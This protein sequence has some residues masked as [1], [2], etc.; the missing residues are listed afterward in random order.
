LTFDDELSVLHVLL[1]IKIKTMKKIATTLFLALCLSIVSTAQTVNPIGGSAIT[2]SVAGDGT[3]VGV[4]ISEDG[5]TLAVGDRFFA[6]PN[7]GNDAGRVRVFK[8]ENGVWVPKGQNLQDAQNFVDYWAGSW[9]D[10]SPDG[11]TMIVGVP[12]LPTSTGTSNSGGAT[13][14]EYD[15]LN[16]SWNYKGN[17]VLANSS[18]SYYGR[19]VA[20]SNSGDVIHV[21]SYTASSNQGRVLSYYYNNGTWNPMGWSSAGNVSLKGTTSGEWYGYA[22]EARTNVAIVGAP[23]GG[24]S[25]NAGY[26]EVREFASSAWGTKGSRINGPSP[27]CRFGSSVEISKDGNRFIAGGYLYNG[28]GTERGYAACYEWDG[29]AWQ[30]LGAPFIGEN[31]GDKLGFGTCINNDGDLVAVAS[32]TSDS[33][34][35]EAGLVRVYHWDGTSW[36]QVGNTL[37]GDNAGDK[38]GYTTVMDGNILAVGAQGGEY[39]KTYEVVLNV[40]GNYEIK[41]MEFKA[42]SVYPNPATNGVN[43]SSYENVEEVIISNIAGQMVYQK[44]LGNTA[45]TYLDLSDLENGVYLLSLKFE[46]GTTQVEKVILR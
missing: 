31:D 45:N 12:R 9:I 35:V 33:A 32:H 6:V 16:N 26:V 14:Y 41:E 37:F 8:M 38:F 44:N 23:E 39:V 46:N 19:K 27:D 1:N 34:G 25:G 22:L 4:S 42:A 11:N 7:G 13:I 40:L 3:G 30:M 15:S 17:V 43:I 21:G 28:G 10:L 2:A 18:N 5:N 20:I 36:N 29:A 24:I